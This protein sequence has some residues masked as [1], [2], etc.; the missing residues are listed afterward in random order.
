MFVCIYSLNYFRSDSYL[1]C[2]SNLYL[3]LTH[4]YHCSSAV[5]IF[6][7]QQRSVQLVCARPFTSIFSPLRSDLGQFVCRLKGGLESRTDHQQTC[8]LIFSSVSSLGVQSSH[9]ARSSPPLSASIWDS[10][11]ATRHKNNELLQNDSFTQHRKSTHWRNNIKSIISWSSSF[12]RSTQ[13]DWLTE[14]Y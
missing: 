4:F 8:C 7:Q 14:I 6:T 12:W 2:R 1:H 3:L 10:N 9:S 11:T 13:T 5:V